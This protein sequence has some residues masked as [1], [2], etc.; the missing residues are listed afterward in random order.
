MDVWDKDLKSAAALPEKL[1][2][3]EEKCVENE[4]G[5]EEEY[6]GRD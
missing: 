6:D 1:L 5:Q 2:E 4:E 3:Y